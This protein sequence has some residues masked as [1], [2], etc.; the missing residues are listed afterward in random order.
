MLTRKGCLT[1]QDRLRALLAEQGI[2]AVV[3]SDPRDVYY[4]SGFLAPVEP[5]LPAML[6]LETEGQTLLAAHTL[7]GEA[8]VDRRVDYE[9]HLLS[10]RNLDLTQRMAGA[11]AEWLAGRPQVPRL[12]WQAESLQRYVGELVGAA[13]R[14]DDW[15]AI[16]AGLA[17]LQRRKE[18]DE[19]ALLRDSISC[20]L[21]AYDADQATIA[22]AV[23]EVAVLAAGSAAAIRRA[24]EHVMHDGDYQ[25]GEQGGFARDRALLAGELY[26]IDAWTI[27]RG[28]WSDLCRTYAVS[29]PTPLQ[30]EVY[31]LVAS[32]LDEMPER[33]RPGLRGTALWRWVDGRLR[34]HPVLRDIGLIHHAGHGV[35]VRAHEEPDLNRDREGVLRPGDV[36]SVEP[37]AYAPELR[38][39][40]RLENTFLI[41]ETGCE[42]LSDYP[43]N[44][45]P[46]RAAPPT[47]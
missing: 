36:V 16:D 42:V 28:Y 9:P 2:G 46:N 8:T 25:S 24:G 3:V 15:I 41:T 40:V 37:G 1:R 19:I 17:D 44:L 38:A 30:V 10:T 21:A 27:Y 23:S 20:T 18:E 32:I 43:L 7:D 31:D 45:I 39:G 35:G 5:P 6:Y 29:E 14:P 22:P 34:E 12:G 33:L 4:L 26:V 13:V 11:A 47:V